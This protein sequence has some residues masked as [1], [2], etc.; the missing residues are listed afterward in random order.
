MPENV[1]TPGPAVPDA[2]LARS[3]F[4]EFFRST[5]PLLRA[6]LVSTFGADVGREAAAEALLYGW[7]NWDRVRELDNPSGFLFRVGQRWGQRHQAR[8]RRRIGEPLVDHV[9]PSFE[10]QLADSLAELPTRQRQA[11][12]L[13]IGYG[14]THAEAAALL[15]IKRSSVQNHVERALRHLRRRLGVIT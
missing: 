12:V 13:C 9:P 14:L 8:G 7:R 15:G 11:V 2:S 5:E 6:A 4:E 10:P 1:R 3:D